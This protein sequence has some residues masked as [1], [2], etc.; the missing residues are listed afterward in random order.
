MRGWRSAAGI[1]Q[2][3]RGGGAASR[4]PHPAPRLA[5]PESLQHLPDF[6]RPTHHRPT[7]EQ[8][9]DGEA[10]VAAGAELGL[11]LGEHS[12]QPDQIGSREQG[13]VLSEHLLHWLGEAFGLASEIRPSTP[14][15][16]AA[17]TG[18]SP[19]DTT[20]SRIE[21]PT[22]MPP[23]A[24]LAIRCSASSSAESP[25][26]LTTCRRRSTIA[27]GPIRRKSKRCRRERIGAAVCA[28]FC[29]SVVANTNTTRGGGSSRILRSA[30]HASRVS[31]CASSTM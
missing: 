2:D 13:A 3:G 18:P 14:R 12:E 28:I 11:E 7:Q 23:S 17:V 19:N 30:F 1:A 8:Q 10:R 4:I 27:W 26:A 6:D 25:S 31:M 16:R 21:S 29:G 9:L 20:W 5:H 22:R 24:L 15:T